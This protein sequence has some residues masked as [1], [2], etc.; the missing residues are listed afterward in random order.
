[1]V[2]LTSP[3][4]HVN[5]IPIE[6]CDD[7]STNIII[8]LISIFTYLTLFNVE[9]LDTSF[10]IGVAESSV[11]VKIVFAFNASTSRVCCTVAVLDLTLVMRVEEEQAVT[12]SA[13]TFLAEIPTVLISILADSP[14][15]NSITFDTFGTSISPID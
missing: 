1:M 8:E 14:A 7:W 2:R 4:V 15:V 10:G 9:L 6:L 12:V 5:G 13:V 11:Q 3:K